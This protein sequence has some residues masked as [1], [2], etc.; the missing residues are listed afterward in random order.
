MGRGKLFF[1]D[2]FLSLCE[3][4]F[5]K[6]ALCDL[7]AENDSRT[8]DEEHDAESAECHRVFR[9]FE[10]GRANNN[11]VKRAYHH[12]DNAVDSLASELDKRLFDKSEGDENTKYDADAERAEQTEILKVKVQKLFYSRDHRHIK[13]K[14]EKYGRA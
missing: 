13:T 6:H 10:G 7:Y 9:F 11:G 8:D 12:T 4:L 1:F 5:V 14:C 3:L 2:V